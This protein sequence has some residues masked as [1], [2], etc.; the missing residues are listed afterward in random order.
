M[1]TEIAANKVVSQ[2]SALPGSGLLASGL[3]IGLVALSS[4][5]SLADDVNSTPQESSLLQLESEVYLPD[6]LWPAEPYIE[7]PTTAVTPPEPLAPPPLE[8]VNV[9]LDW[10]LSPQHAALLI[11]YQK[12]FFQQQ[13][14]EV[15]W[16][17]PGDPSLPT[18]LLAAGEVDLALGRQPLLHLSV[19]G[20]ASLTRIAT[21]VNTPLN[22]IITLENGEKHSLEKLGT[23]PLGYT[24]LEGQQLILPL[25]ISETV[26]QSE[27]YA[28][29]QAIH[30][31]TAQSLTEGGLEGVADA[32]FH[33]LPSRLSTQGQPTTVTRY[34]ALS[35]PRHDGLIVMA[36]RNTLGRRMETWTRFVIALEDAANWI[37]ENP[38]NAKETVTSAYPRLENSVTTDS[39]EDLLRRFS[40]T[41][42]ALDL[43][44]YQ[45]M[46]T[47]LHQHD[48][49]S[50]IL[51]IEQ[52]A[53]DPNRRL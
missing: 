40:L 42:A 8:H 49:T 7:A 53:V 1:L 6:E 51:P 48:I 9:M 36:N 23:R 16:Q 3:L 30:F 41:P 21:L 39:W 14:L 13:G 11:A 43:R 17:I 46:E 29:P 2:S 45:D 31:E 44:R 47:F 33:T 20:G 18:K 4:T 22:A 10:F 52:L 34:E 32:F 5:A 50:E 27:H 26:S 37:I 28:K 38:E 25:L 19:H 24:T 12:G 15:S 35:I